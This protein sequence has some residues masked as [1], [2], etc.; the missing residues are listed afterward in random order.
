M[1]LRGW[2]GRL[3]RTDLE[4]LERQEEGRAERLRAKADAEVAKAKADAESRA[5]IPPPTSML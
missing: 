2:I 4:K 5:M 3:F 1:G